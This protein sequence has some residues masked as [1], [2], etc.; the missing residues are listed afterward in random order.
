MDDLPQWALP[1]LA[2]PQV[3][4]R[5]RA[6]GATILA[7]ALPLGSYPRCLGDLL[8]ANAAARP[9]QVFLGERTAGPHSPW[10]TVTW[11]QALTR[12]RSL[13]QALIDLGAGPERP[14]LLL[15]GNSIAHALLTLAAMHVGIPAVPVSVAYSLVSRDFAKLELI[16]Q[17]ITPGVVFVEQ[18]KPF[19]PALEAAG[20]AALPLICGDAS[21][22][23]PADPG[24]RARTVERYES[25]LSLAPSDEVDRRFAQLG[26]DTIAKVLFTSG[27]TGLP[28]GVLN[29]QRMLCSN[30]AALARVW[31]FLGE[32]AARGRVPVICDWLPWNHTFGANF[33]FNLILMHGGS[34]WIDAGKPGPGAFE[35]TLAN[36]RERSPTLYFN[37]PRGF[38]LLVPELEADAELRERFFANLDLVFYAAAALPQRLWT[39]L[40][41]LAIAARGQRLLMV[42]AWGSTETAPCSTAVYWPI[43]R[44][45]VI[46][47]PM[48]GTEIALID[49]G[50]K[51]ELRVRGPNVTPGYWRDA[52]LS[53]A[54][55]DEFGFYRIGDAGKLAD[56]T[57][58]ELGLEFDGRVSEDFKLSSGTWVHAGKL[59]LQAIAACEPLVED[60]VLAGH[61]RAELGLLLFPNLAACRELAG[62]DRAATAQ[63]VVSHELVRAAVS[64]ALAAHNRQHPSSST[65][66]ARAILLADPPSIDANEITDKGYINQR[67]VL[68][69][70]ATLVESLFSDDRDALTVGTVDCS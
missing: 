68:S 29:T 61:D 32:D 15:S 48:P 6:D 5:R 41:Q 28:K 63:Q 33:N 22:G 40:E 66:F 19:I 7:N 38:E 21:P 24:P 9:D 60:C 17:Q 12:V 44:A 70:R 4:L 45:G 16:S 53:D 62:L 43:E 65:R 36:L 37:V 56:P 35:A 47:N 27:S 20:L 11:A 69:H 59:R 25:L 55:F 52:Q 13:A 14:L 58:P 64:R 18:R 50:D 10:Q 23:S 2:S 51:Q 3:E 26:P 31:P 30:Q 34:L 42:S 39:R 1:K 57:R 46:G 67:A 8:V 49:N 54:A